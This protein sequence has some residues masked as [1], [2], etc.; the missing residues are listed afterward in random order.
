VIFDDRTL[1][2]LARE[3]PRTLLAMS[4]IRGVGERKLAEL[5]EIFL[6]EIAA[7]SAGDS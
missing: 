5:G 3:R 4:R 2:G 1:R 6:A 7:W